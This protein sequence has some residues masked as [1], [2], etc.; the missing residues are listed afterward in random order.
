MPRTPTDVSRVHEASKRIGETFTE[1]SK[2]ISQFSR[3]PRL[4]LPCLRGDYQVVVN[5]VTAW[6]AVERVTQD[7]S[8]EFLVEFMKKELRRASGVLQAKAFREG[9]PQIHEDPNLDASEL[10]LAWAC[11]VFAWAR[12]HE[13]TRGATGARTS[14]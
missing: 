11:D 10:S 13:A 1:A 3:V 5:W 9:P 4:P 8:S 6:A 7:G 12:Q 14:G 2:Y